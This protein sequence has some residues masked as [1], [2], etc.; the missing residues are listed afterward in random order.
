MGQ[1]GYGNVSTCLSCDSVDVMYLPKAHNWYY[2]YAN[3]AC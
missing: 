1:P 3:V 2:L